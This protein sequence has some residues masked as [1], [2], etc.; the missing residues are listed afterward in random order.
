MSLDGTTPS[1]LM[2]FWVVALLGLNHLLM[3]IPGVIQRMWA[4]F[5]VQA[6]NLGTA[7]WMMAVG[8]PDFKQDGN[9]WILN[10][11]LGFLLIFHIIQNN[12]RLQ[13]SKKR[14]GRPSPAEVRAERERIEDALKRGKEETL[15][16]SELNQADGHDAAPED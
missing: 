10:W 6:L 8:I 3:R 15:T 7:T 5:S 13:R 14:G 1:D 11:V 16:S 2:L 4:F 12:N 9:L